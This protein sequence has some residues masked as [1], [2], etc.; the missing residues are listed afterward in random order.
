MELTIHG[1]KHTVHLPGLLLLRGPPKF[2]G[3]EDGRKIVAGKGNS[4]QEPKPSPSELITWAAVLSPFDFS[5]LCPPH[6]VVS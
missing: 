4:E 2:W 6:D 3:T 5:A 1:E